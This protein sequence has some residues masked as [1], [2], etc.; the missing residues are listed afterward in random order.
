MYIVATEL[1]RS[2]HLTVHRF[3]ESRI[4][5]S[6]ILNYESREIYLWIFAIV[7][8]VGIGIQLC[9]LYPLRDSA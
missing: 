6:R 8:S 1:G 2:T 5:T 4:I 7:V 3:Y 9:G